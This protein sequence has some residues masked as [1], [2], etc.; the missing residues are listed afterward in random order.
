[1]SAAVIEF[2]PR[3]A[4]A[5]HAPRLYTEQDLRLARAA[6]YQEGVDHAT[7]V[8]L[9]LD[10]MLSAGSCSAPSPTGWAS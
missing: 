1:M 3:R 10:R 7:A 5:R 6:G 8:Y 9:D 2:V 4:A